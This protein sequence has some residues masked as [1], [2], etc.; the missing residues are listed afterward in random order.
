M[1]DDPEWHEE[2]A[3]E[4]EHGEREVHPGPPTHD[5]ADSN[6][7]ESHAPASGADA[8]AD[9]IG[10]HHREETG[11]TVDDAAEDDHAGGDAVAQPVTEPAEGLL[12]LGL[13][14]GGKD[15]GAVHGDR[16]FQQLADLG[17][18]Q[19]TADPLQLAVY[20]LAWA[21]LVGVEPSAVDAVFLYV[22][23]GQEARYGD[24]LP[25]EEELAQLLRGQVEVEALTLL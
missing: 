17:T 21:R 6:S 23:T 3:P 9:Q 8:A 19:L 1:Q 4:Q 7:P 25:G 13:D 24:E 12:G 11:T 14:P 22:A 20:R 15:A 10:R 2:Q 18:C 5:P 16:L